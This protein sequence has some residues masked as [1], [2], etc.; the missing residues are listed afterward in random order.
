MVNFCHLFQSYLNRIL[1]QALVISIA[2]VCIF[3]CF[4]PDLSGRSGNFISGSPAY[5]QAV[6]NTEVTKYARAVLVMEPVRQTAFNEI[7]KMIRSGDIPPIVCHK[8]KSLNALPDNARQVAINYCKRSKEIVE[9]NGLTINRF[10]S[11]TI[12]LQNDSN[13]KRRIHNEL[14]RI[15]NSASH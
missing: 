11:I 4:I 2:T 7:K 6:S 5:A 14:L 10:N 9:S 13:L 8:S 3:S 12:N 15:Q 1:S